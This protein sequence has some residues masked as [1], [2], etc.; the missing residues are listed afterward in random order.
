MRVLEWDSGCEDAAG[1]HDGFHGACCG[2]G[3]QSNRY[4]SA[5]GL[6]NA[7]ALGLW[8]RNGQVLCIDN[9]ENDKQGHFRGFRY[10]EFFSICVGFLLVEFSTRSKNALHRLADSE[11]AIKRWT[12]G[13]PSEVHR[14]VFC[15]RCFF[16]GKTPLKKKHRTFGGPRGGLS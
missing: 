9:T 16:Q 8:A 12:S 6:S 10:K 15:R 13:G 14:C 1:A 4:P 7:P 2:S 3:D 11:L 5:R